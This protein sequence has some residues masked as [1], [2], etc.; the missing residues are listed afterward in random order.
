MNEENKTDLDP[1]EQLLQKGG[2]REQVNQK[3]FDRVE[4]H[5]FEHWQRAVEANR[6]QE[7]GRKRRLI[8]T[9]LAMAATVVLA[10]ILLPRVF[11]PVPLVADVVTTV[12]IV[13]SGVPGEPRPVEDQSRGW[14]VREVHGPRLRRPGVAATTGRRSACARPW[15]AARA[16]FGGS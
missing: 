2:R 5:A 4:Q 8:V 15:A 9:R 11:A 10:A 3:R 12:G 7:R 13:E 6:F 14:E 1:I 16:G